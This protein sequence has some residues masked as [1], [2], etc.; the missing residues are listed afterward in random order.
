MMVYFH[1]LGLE[2]PLPGSVQLRYPT[3]LAL[4]DAT[5]VLSLIV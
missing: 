5:G 3:F 1:Y 4:L 2:S